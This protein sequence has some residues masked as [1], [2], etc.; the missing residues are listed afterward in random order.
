MS[1]IASQDSD[2]NPTDQETADDVVMGDATLNT[3]AQKPQDDE[4]LPPWLMAK[5]EYLRSVNDDTVWQNLVTD[6]VD[7]EK[8]GPPSGVSSFK[9]FFWYEI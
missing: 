7:F 1:I 8:G 4:N 2:E 9:L 6:F 3:P 5:I